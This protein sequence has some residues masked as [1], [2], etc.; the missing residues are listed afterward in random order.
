VGGGGRLKETQSEWGK[1]NHIMKVTVDEKG[2]T[3]E[4]IALPKSHRI[5]DDLKEWAFGNVLPLFYH[6]AWMLYLI[7]VLVFV[8]G[9]VSLFFFLKLFRG[10]HEDKV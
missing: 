4:I 1:F 7:T 2:I 8:W 5:R 3:E 9:M 6:Q 10:R